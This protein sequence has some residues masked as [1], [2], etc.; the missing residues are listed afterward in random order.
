MLSRREFVVFCGGLVQ[1]PFLHWDGLTVPGHGIAARAP[2]LPSW[3]DGA[4]VQAVTGMGGAWVARPVFERT[5]AAARALGATVLT[6][7]VKWNATAPFWSPA[8]LLTPAGRR[9]VGAMIEEAHRNGVRLILYYWHEGDDAY[10]AAHPDVSCRMPDG[11]IASHPV[12]GRLLDVT[13]PGYGALVKARLSEMA[14]LG[15]DG[16]YFDYTH[17]PPAGCLDTQ[18]ERTFDGDGGPSIP[19]NAARDDEPAYHAFL[20]Y[21]A[22]RITATFEDWKASVQA[23]APDTLFVIST[24]Y[25]PSL[26]SN[27]MNTDLVRAADAPKTEIYVAV[28]PQLGLGMFER[29]KPLAWVG[30]DERLVMGYCYLRDAGAGRPP[31]VWAPGFMAAPEYPRFVAAVL[32]F[33]CI[34]AVNLPEP[35]LN[36][37]AGGGSEAEREGIPAA[38]AVGARLSEELHATHPLRWLVVHVSER[39]R[40]ARGADIE[41]ACREVIAPEIGAFVT[42]LHLGVPVGIVTDRGLAAGIPASAKVLVLPDPAALD[43]G[44]RAAVARFRQRGGTVVNQDGRWDWTGDPAAAERALGTRLARALETVPLRVTAR[45][46]R[47][48]AAAHASADGRRL[49]IGVTTAFSGLH[50]ESGQAVPGAVTAPG[51]LTGVEISCRRARAISRAEDVVDGTVLNA[52]PRGDGY[53]VTLPVVRPF[54][55]IAIRTD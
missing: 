46:G 21:T 36:D 25:L 52:E 37:A 5:G 23:H 16:F 41:R 9:T 39:A 51:D 53:V 47:P 2:S 28:R 12:R 13:D 1:V 43:D 48:F 40:D 8:G 45:S 3:F 32:T 44:Q 20:G 4:R 17:L 29:G 19:R 50:L 42:G 6:R 7:Y 38:F 55:F 27:R 34:A 10:A 31:H 26:V 18:L 33:G 24:T 35:L 11:A 54:A 49:L 14:G 30:A 22:R 15:A